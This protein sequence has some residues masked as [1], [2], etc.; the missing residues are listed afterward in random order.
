MTTVSPA[1]EICLCG[2]GSAYAECCELYHCGLQLPDTAERLMR[3][4]FT[5]YAKHN[6]DYLLA[7][8][9]AS[10][11]PVT[12]DFSKE[13]AEWQRLQIISCKKGGTTDS[14]GIVEFKAFYEQDG[15]CCFMHEISRFIKTGGHWL[16]LDGVIKA[17]GKVENQVNAGKNALCACGSGK[18]SKRCCGKL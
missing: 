8:W 18:K 13:T 17:A 12:I 9:D 15:V 4:R 16:Y 14:K 3:S 11:R 2:S 1:D 10:K 6:A 5:A 7:S